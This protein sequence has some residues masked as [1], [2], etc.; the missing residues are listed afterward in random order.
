MSASYLS[1]ND[2]LMRLLNDN[3]PAARIPRHG[4]KQHTARK[5]QRKQEGGSGMHN[6]RSGSTHNMR[7]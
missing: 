7:S 6:K 4:D 5:P 1:L 3:L 2:W